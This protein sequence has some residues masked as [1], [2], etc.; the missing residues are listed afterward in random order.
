[1]DEETGVTS[2][3]MLFFGDAIYPGGNDNAVRAAGIDSV[4]VRDPAETATAITAVL[5]CL[6]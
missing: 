2:H 5:A 3:E 1:M 4:K 6:E